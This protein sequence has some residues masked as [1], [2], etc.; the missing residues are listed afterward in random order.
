MEFCVSC[1]MLQGQR[2]D[3]WEWSHVHAEADT[4]TSIYTLAHFL[5]L[6]RN[7]PCDLGPIS[8]SLI[9]GF[10]TYPGEL[11]FLQSAII[12]IVSSKHLWTILTKLGSY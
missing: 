10:L 7:W 8:N 12:R 11:E 6:P 2:R 4:W 5:D 3:T 9:L 1:R